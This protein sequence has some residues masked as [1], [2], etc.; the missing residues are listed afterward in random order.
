MARRVSNVGRMRDVKTASKQLVSN[1]SCRRKPRHVDRAF[2]ATAR[3]NAKYGR[4]FFQKRKVMETVTRMHMACEE[5]KP[6]LGKYAEPYV[7]LTL[8]KMVEAGYITM[9]DWED[10]I[11]ITPRAAKM[12]RTID[13]L[14]KARQFSSLL[15]KLNAH[16]DHFRQRVGTAPCQ[17]MKGLKAQIEH[18]EQRWTDHKRVCPIA[19]ED[20]VSSNS[21]SLANEETTHPISGADD[22]DMDEEQPISS[23][24][25]TPAEQTSSLTPS[26]PTQ[27]HSPPRLPDMEID[28]PIVGPSSISMAATNATPARKS[29]LTDPTIAYL[30][31]VTLPRR[32]EGTRNTLSPP[33]SPSLH[34]SFS[35][36]HD[37]DAAAGMDIDDDSNSS[38]SGGSPQ[39]IT[40]AP[41]GMFVQHQDQHHDLEEQIRHLQQ[42]LAAK[43]ENE[44]EMTR[45][46][47]KLKRNI[48]ADSIL[49][50]RRLDEQNQKLHALQVKLETVV[51]KL[52]HSELW[53]K[54]VLAK[55]HNLENKYHLLHDQGCAEARASAATIRQLQIEKKQVEELAEQHDR[56]KR[57]LEEEVKRTNEKLDKNTRQLQRM[58]DLAEELSIAA[59][60]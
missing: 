28:E 25:S 15:E 47:D 57:Q 22:V 9:N 4:V 13:D 49:A 26:S 12:M 40:P 7:E 35:L 59:Q 19:R 17:T 10:M 1:V 30:T 31:P 6:P 29:T 33:P 3:L 21:S 46:M 44:K 38:S 20:S 11:Q 18:L 39:T 2:V 51:S 52:Y 36:V 48:A 24:P 32:R 42:Q 14:M 41:V 54:Q 53:R 27:C 50:Q 43:A 56:A 8:S 5:P 16:C 45:N 37:D 60:E 58:R 34:R 55:I 23:A